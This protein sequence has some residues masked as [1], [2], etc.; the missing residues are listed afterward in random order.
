[1]QISGEDKDQDRFDNSDSSDPCSVAA[2]RK[3]IV[4]LEIELYADGIYEP[5]DYLCGALKRFG[6]KVDTGEFGQV[7]CSAFP[8]LKDVR[9]IGMDD[10]DG[11]KKLQL[12]LKGRKN[13]GALTNEQVLASCYVG[14]VRMYKAIQEAEGLINAAIEDKPDVIS[15]LLDQ[16]ADPNARWWREETALHSCHSSP[17]AARLLLKRGA[18]VNAKTEY[19]DVP[20]HSCNSEVA[21]VL[22]KA[23]ADLNEKNNQDDTPLHRAVAEKRVEVVKILID[24]GADVNIGTKYKTSPLHDCRDPIIAE[25]LIEAGAKVDEEN[26]SMRDTPISALLRFTYS[27]DT[28]TAIRQISMLEKLHSKGARLGIKGVW[29]AIDLANTIDILEWLFEN[30]ADVNLAVDSEGNTAL[31]RLAESFTNEDEYHL[32]KAKWLLAHGADKG[33]RNADGKTAL[34]IAKEN[35]D[36]GATDLVKLLQKK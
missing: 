28:E 1:M 21:E 3:E 18:D 12:R 10:S 17:A 16:G 4:R 31:M 23:G 22:I 6:I 36:P 26:L 7:L 25:L 19:G 20:L 34:D 32:K 27:R 2:Y 29:S 30:G 13:I 5:P 33:L 35:P 24:S 8:M 14:T 11:Q 9:I 15:G